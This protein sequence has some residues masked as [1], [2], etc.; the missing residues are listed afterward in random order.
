MDLLQKPIWN[1]K[2]IQA[3]TGCSPTTAVKIRK[4]AIEKYDGYIPMLPKSIK[5]DAVLKALNMEVVG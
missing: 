5:R 4:E 2:D 1:N 3:F